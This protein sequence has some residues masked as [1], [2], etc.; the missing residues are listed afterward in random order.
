EAARP[1]TIDLSEKFHALKMPANQGLST[2][3]LIYHYSLPGRAPARPSPSS[4]KTFFFKSGGIP[5]PG[6]GKAIVLNSNRIA[7]RLL[8]PF[9]CDVG[10]GLVCPACHAIDG[11]RQPLALHR[12]TLEGS[13]QFRAVFGLAVL[14]STEGEVIEKRLVVH[15]NRLLF[16]EIRTH[17]F[18]GFTEGLEEVV[19][20]GPR[21]H[22]LNGVSSSA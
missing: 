7:M 5:R 2:T 13:Q 15:Q 4:L 20:H 3:I 17:G 9:S 6:P 11:Q 1:H 12:F 22:R 10:D 21:Y 18:E 19:F 16:S 8:G 14:D